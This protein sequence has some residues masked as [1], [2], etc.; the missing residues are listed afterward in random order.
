MIKINLANSESKI[1]KEN[2][3][4]LSSRVNLIYGKNG[5]GK[6]TLCNL[7]KEQLSEEYDVKIFNGFDS[8]LSENDRLDLVT[9]GEENVQIERTIK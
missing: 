6:S 1:Y 3:L 5:T 8:V 7:I 2:S 4:E 9:L